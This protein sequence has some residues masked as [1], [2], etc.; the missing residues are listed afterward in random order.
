METIEGFVNFVY[1]INFWT[2]EQAQSNDC[3]HTE[4]TTNVINRH[5]MLASP[6]TKQ[7]VSNKCHKRERQ[8]NQTHASGSDNFN[9]AEEVRVECSGILSTIVDLCTLKCMCLR[10]RSIF[11]DHATSSFRAVP[12]SAMHA[13]GKCRPC[14][15]A[16]RGPYPDPPPPTGRPCK[17][18]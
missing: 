3:K 17:N 9:G 2:R 12:H 16:E 1:F 10:A 11:C 13:L 7:I 5:Y 18:K 15:P 14:S 6:S 4:W 8:V